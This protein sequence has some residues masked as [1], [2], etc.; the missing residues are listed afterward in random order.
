MNAAGSGVPSTPED[1]AMK[2]NST[3]AR[4]DQVAMWNDTA[5]SATLVTLGT[6]GRSNDTNSMIA[7][8]FTEKKGYSRF[9]S[10]FGNGNIDSPMVYCGFSPA[11]VT[12]WN[13]DS[14]GSN[15]YVF[16][17]KRLGYNLDNERID[18][19]TTAAEGTDDRLDFLSN[20]FKSRNTGNPNTA[21][22]WIYAAFAEA[23]FVNSSGV[24]CNAR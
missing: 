4:A 2:F 20:G 15:K 13:A 14:A 11:L 6:E 24:P 7:Y 1:Y 17:N 3:G 8:C 10:Y 19:N 18:A 16:D 22:L 21:T 9:S 12:I 23:P 5:P